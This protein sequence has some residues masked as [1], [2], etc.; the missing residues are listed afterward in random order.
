MTGRLTVVPLRAGEALLMSSVNS[1]H[2]MERLAQGGMHQYGP[3]MQQQG[4][5]ALQVMLPSQHISINR[6]TKFPNLCMACYSLDYE[7]H[8]CLLL[9]EWKHRGLVTFDPMGCVIF[10]NGMLVP[11]DESRMVEG[12]EDAFPETRKAGMS[13]GAAAMPATGAN[14]TPV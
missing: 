2:G 12:V 7:K 4:V 13:R 10:S 6:A 1:V 9:T 14:S 11:I 8:D 5:G 3:P